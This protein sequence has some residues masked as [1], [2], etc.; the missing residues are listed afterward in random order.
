MTSLLLAC[1]LLFLGSVLTK[2]IL[3]TILFNLMSLNL[4]T[5][6]LSKHFHNFLTKLVS[7]LGHSCFCP[8][9]LTGFEYHMTICINSCMNLKAHW[10]E[11][12]HAK[13]DGWPLKKI[14]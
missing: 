3:K 6:S 2:I 7:L 4:I 5:I 11:R 14:P 13:G 8:Y 12:L 1:A 10:L 9:F